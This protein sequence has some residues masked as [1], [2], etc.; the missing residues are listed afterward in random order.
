M[1][2]IALVVLTAL[3]FTPSSLRAQTPV[4]TYQGQLSAAGGVPASGWYD[5]T[6][7]LYD[8][9]GGAAQ[10]GGT[11]STNALP[12][13]GGN[14]AVTLGFGAGAFS[15]ADRWL[16]IAVRTNGSGTFTTL[17]PRQRI[18]PTPYAIRA[19][20]AAVAAGVAAGAVGSAALQAGSV[21]ASKIADGAI[22]L[23]DLSGTVASNTFWRLSGNLGTTAGTHFIGTRDNQAVE[24][25]VNDQRALRLEPNATSPN[26][27]GGYSGNVV[28]NGVAGAVIGG[29]GFAANENRVGGNNSAVLSGYRNEAYGGSAVVAGGDN[30]VAGRDRG[31]IGGGYG[32]RVT[33]TLGTVAG[34]DSNSAA[35]WYSTVPGGSRN[36]AGADYSLAAGNRAKAT[37]RGAFVWS[38]AQNADF[39]ST[40]TNQFLVR[41]SGGVGLGTNNPQAQL[42]VRGTNAADYFR[43]DGSLL[44]N[45]AF[46]SVL[47]T[48]NTFTASNRFA[49]VTTATNGANQFGGTFSGAVRGDGSGLTNLNVSLAGAWGINGNAGTSSGTHFLGTTD[50]RALDFRVNSARALRL[51]PNATSPNVVAG[52]SGNVVSN[53]VY[54]SVIAGGGMQFNVNRMGGNFSAISGG[55]NN[56]V[57]GAASFVGGGAYNVAAGN[58]AAVPGG[59]RNEAAQH[60]S[61]AAGR[62]AKANHQGAFV[63]ADSQDLDFASSAENQFLVRAGGGVGIGTAN[64]TGLLTVRGS[65]TGNWT[66]PLSFIENNNPSGNSGPALRLL[67]AGHSPD[68]V[69]NVGSTGTGK[70]AAFGNAAGEVANLDTNGLLTLKAGV[71]VDANSANSNG[72]SSGIQFGLG[73]GEGIFSR[74]GVA[75]PNQWGLDLCTY[76]APRVSIANNGDVGIGTGTNG[77]QAKFHVAGSLLRVD[78]PANEQAYLGGDGIGNDVQV[79]SLNSNVTQVTLYNASTRSFMDLYA[80]QASVT[81]LDIRG[82]SDV[83]EPFELSQQNIPKGAVVVIDDENPGKLKLA[84]RPYDTRVAG[85]VSGANG[86]RPGLTLRQEGVLEGTEH[87]ALTGRVYALADA[88]ETPIKPGDLLTTSATPG[89]VMTASDRT[90]AYGAILGKAM[91]GLKEGRGLVLVL[92]SLQ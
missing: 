2:R 82:G 58:Y 9:L 29:G 81:V 19:A 38:D 16:E 17:S 44:T 15:G 12:V 41:A 67:S 61:F 51:E 39:G 49:G 87:I 14:F 46:G 54:G 10:V 30:N 62:R 6:F 72:L 73:S 27:V 47:G 84:D 18:T 89:H 70:L 24:V 36:V 76:W 1:K 63:W 79:G 80:Q 20:D 83:A 66:S 74:R 45:L 64:V 48:N 23:A 77:P 85:I 56:E 71:I 92:V 40:G 55:Y 43:G 35:G 34:G 22:S 50:D 42:H 57:R 33:G 3:V 31:T 7:K 53:G 21:D 8:A 69:L 68:A 32:N 65:R 5:F 59:L 52:Y 13:T 91:T 26:L 37:N 88:G 28:S 90:Q 60:Y 25:K 78:G 4:F 75:G 11:V 86:V